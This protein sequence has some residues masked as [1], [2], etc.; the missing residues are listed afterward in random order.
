MPEELTAILNT[1]DR[2]HHFLYYSYL[3]ARKHNAQHYGQFTDEGELT[4][5]LAFLKGLP[6]YAFSAYAV[7]RAFQLQPVLSYIKRQLQLPDQATGSFILNEQEMAY[8]SAQVNFTRPP[9]GLILMKHMNLK[10][11]PPQDERVQQLASFSFPQIEELMAELNTMAFTKE[12]LNYPFFGALAE[13]KLIAAGGYHIYNGDYAELGNI[14]TNTAWRRQGYGRSISAE[15]T[16]NARALT[17]NVYLNVLEENE[18]AIRLYES[19]GYERIC[20]QYIVEFSLESGYVR[21]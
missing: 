17:P 7:Q 16:R 18:A 11:L 9:R 21:Q 12:E 14:G 3:T 1:I 6:F 20:K 19:L 15:L 2:D 10:A 5:V 4:G 13:Q 8:L